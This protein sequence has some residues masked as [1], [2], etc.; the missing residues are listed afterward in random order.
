MTPISINSGLQAA[1][2]GAS[3]RF[4]ALDVVTNNL[5]NANT[6]GFKRD[7]PCFDAT[8]SQLSSTTPLTAIHLRETVADQSQGAINQTGN[9]FDLAIDGEG[10]LEVMTPAGSRYTRQG[11]LQLD[12]Q[13]QLVTASGDPVLAG[14]SPITIPSGRFEVQQDGTITA[15]GATIG[16]LNLVSYPSGENPRKAGN[17]LFLPP[18][19]GKMQAVTKPHFIQGS[20]ESSNVNIM[21]SMTRM[22]TYQREFETMQKMIKTYNALAAKA[23][24]LGSL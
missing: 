7:I 12:P 22:I 13:G 10:Y 2:T 15:G 3:A 4:Q 1:V 21:E 5:A 14:G 8:L 17:G 24:E 9:P 23:D 20:I 18:T 11:N 6:T 16:K 19:Q